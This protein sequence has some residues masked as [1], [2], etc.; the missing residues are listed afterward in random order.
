MLGE[1]DSGGWNSLT[2]NRRIVMARWTAARPPKRGMA[3]NSAA[4]YSHSLS[5]RERNAD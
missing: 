2:V 5:V 1:N 4:A 3:I